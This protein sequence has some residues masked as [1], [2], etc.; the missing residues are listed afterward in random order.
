MTKSYNKLVRDKIPEIIAFSGR[1]ARTTSLDI[2]GAKFAECL[3]TK[4]QEEVDEFLE[5]P[6]IEEIADIIE[7]LMT[8][9]STMGHNWEEVESARVEKKKKRGGF[10]HGVFLKETIEP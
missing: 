7:V 4:L 3:R 8:L 9:A 2:D 6:S 10:E 5:L 1:I